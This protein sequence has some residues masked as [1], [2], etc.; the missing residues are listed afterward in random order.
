MKKILSQLV[1]VCLVALLSVSVA[2]ASLGKSKWPIKISYI[3]FVDRNHEMVKNIQEVFAE[4]EKRSQ[5]KVKFDYKGGPESVKIFLQVMNV[6]QGSTDMVFT[7]PS[8]M[9]KFI[10]GADTLTMSEI[11]SSQMK[12]SGL[13]DYLNQILAKKNLHFLQMYPS[14]PGEAYVVLTKKPIASISDFNGLSCRGG[15]WMDGVAPKLGMSTVSMKHFEEYSGLEK[16]MIDIGRM[17]LDSMYSFRLHEVAKYL[18]EPS[19]GIRPA[20][21]FMNQRKWDS[22]PG[23]VQKVIE[24]TMYEMADGVA[25]KTT[26][27][28]AE[29]K[30]KMVSEGMEVIQLEGEQKEQYVKAM[31]DGM[32]EYFSKDDPEVAKKIYELT[33]KSNVE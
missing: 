4:V 24:D 3:T 5:G 20:S 26:S 19:F 33:R 14:A 27:A 7:T 23:D 12:N 22:I 2:N 32:F 31:H 30:K 11:P 8:F 1:V 17:T 21:L 25:E 6:V 9:G 28:L 10:K 16:G 18:I 13:Y 15:D 29:M